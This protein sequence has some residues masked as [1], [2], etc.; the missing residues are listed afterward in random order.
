M[1]LFYTRVREFYEWLGTIQIFGYRFDKR[2]VKFL[3]VGGLNTLFGYGMFV[4]FR[5]L[6]L[7]FVFATLCAHICGVLFNFKTTGAFVFKSHNNRL[8]LR[9]FLVYAFIYLFNVLCIWIL[10]QFNF[11]DY[12][13][14]AI[15]LLPQAIVS[16]L[17]MR[18]FV[19]R[20]EANRLHEKPSSAMPE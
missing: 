18:R 16:F 12:A 19:F 2:F 17:L 1:I 11:N 5:A 14:A 8:I 10:K 4:F 3:F 6:G 9:F 13:A 20:P 7:Y 15:V